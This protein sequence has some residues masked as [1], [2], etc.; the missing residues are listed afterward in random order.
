MFNWLIFSGKKFSQFVSGEKIVSKIKKV[1]KKTK[2]KIINNKCSLFFTK[3]SIFIIHSHTHNKYEL[4]K[5]MI[6][7]S[8]YNKDIKKF[9]RVKINI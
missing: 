4:Q 2:T 8:F 3:F 7:N 9:V 6:K 5:I 1:N